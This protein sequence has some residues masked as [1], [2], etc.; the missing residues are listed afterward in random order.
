MQWLGRDWRLQW[1]GVAFVLVSV[2]LAFYN[3]YVFWVIMGIWAL[4]VMILP[5]LVSRDPRRTL[6]LE[7]IVLACIPFVML[8]VIMLGYGSTEWYVIDIRIPEVVATVFIGFLTV[9][10]LAIHTEMRMNRFFAIVLTVMLTVSVASFFAIANYVAA[11]LG[12][13]DVLPEFKPLT[14][15][16]MNL[17]YAFIGGIVMGVLLDTYLKRMSPE[18]LR[19]YG[20]CQ[21]GDTPE[22]GC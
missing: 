12:G 3:Q 14:F 5:A 11:V 17:I 4:L 15:L 21:L 7:L 1:V 19:A 10:D 6:P 22:G 13:V 8:W 20:I 16:M 9:M 2:L 18:R